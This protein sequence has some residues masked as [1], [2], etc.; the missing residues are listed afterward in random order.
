M[1]FIIVPDSFLCRLHFDD[2]QIEQNCTMF[3]SQISTAKQF[4]FYLHSAEENKL[5][6][7]SAICKQILYFIIFSSRE[8]L[9]SLW[10]RM[11]RQAKSV[12]RWQ[13]F[14]FYA[15]IILALYF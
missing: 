15:K 12:C 3:R 1:E 11:Q 7:N 8:W 6:Q 5:K 14:I 13:S 2:M 9:Y 10:H 4:D